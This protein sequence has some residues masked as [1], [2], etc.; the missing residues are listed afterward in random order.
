VIAAR[1]TFR[2]SIKR[3]ATAGIVALF[4]AVLA[5]V[6]HA[7]DEDSLRPGLG[8][9]ATPG[10]VARWDLTVFPDG[11]GLPPG[12]GTVAEGRAVY[13]RRC[14]ACHGER[15]TG[16]SGGHL[17][18]RG[19]L[20][21]PDAD[22]TVGSYWPFATT[23]FDFVRRSMPMD[24]PGSLST[25]ETYAVTAYVLHE[26]G[27]VAADAAMDARTLPRVRM[28]NREGFVGVDAPWPRGDDARHTTPAGATRSR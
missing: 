22:R 24:A 8:T 15:G 26:N 6:A 14:A 9:A 7:A 10:E 20:T 17:V 27:I 23:L 21:G 16:G 3:S 4:A 25:D 2:P 18:G 12:R 5:A 1:G 28:P 11:R 19:P 13:D